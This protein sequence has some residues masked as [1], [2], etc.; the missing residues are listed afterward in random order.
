MGRLS[1]SRDPHPASSHVADLGL[2]VAAGHRRRGVG[3]ALLEQAVEW[4]RDSRV[5]KLELHVFPHN[6]P[7]IALYERFG[8]VREGYRH[9]HYRR[10]DGLRGRDSDGVSSWSNP[11]PDRTRRRIRASGRPCRCR[12]A[13]SFDLTLASQGGD[14]PAR[15]ARRAAGAA[16]APTAARAAPAWARARSRLAPQARTR[17]CPMISSGS[18]TSRAGSF[19]ELPEQRRAL[20]R[21][22]VVAGPSSSSSQR[23]DLSGREGCAP[24]SAPAGG[25]ARSPR[26]PRSSARRRRPAG[27][28]RHGRRVPTSRRPCSS[29]E[30]EPELAAFPEAF[31]DQLLVARLEDVQRDPLGRQ[32]HEL[33][34][35][36]ADLGHE[37][38]RVVGPP[39]PVPIDR[40]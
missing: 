24:R 17:A 18:S 9:A 11:P 3:R 7:A 15:A 26:R 21:S 32:Q 1:I 40:R 8:F 36:Q 23:L 10:G 30:H 6:A 2:M 16:R 33:E 39:L 12:C 28:R 19:D 13:R 34:R 22:S 14:R 31:A 20:A 38:R 29:C 37:G 5:R 35:E 4:A 27:P 25:S